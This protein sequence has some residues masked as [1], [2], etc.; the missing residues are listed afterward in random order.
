M[1][2]MKI[3]KFKLFGSSDGEKGTS[4]GQNVYYKLMIP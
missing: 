3:H 4:G 1:K 2:T